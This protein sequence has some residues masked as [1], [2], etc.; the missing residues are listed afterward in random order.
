[1]TADKAEKGD[2]LQGLNQTLTSVENELL[3]K[4]SDRSDKRYFDVL[5]HYA[6]KEGRSEV[7]ASAPADGGG[8]GA[9]D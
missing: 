1:M 7:P 3:R 6:D 5:K 4:R 8:D 9:E 2:K